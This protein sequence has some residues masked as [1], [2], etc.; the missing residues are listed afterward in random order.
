MLM[1][2]IGEGGIVGVRMC[3]FKKMIQF[4]QQFYFDFYCVVV[5]GFG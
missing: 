5:C 2:F 4:D 3:L 1:Q